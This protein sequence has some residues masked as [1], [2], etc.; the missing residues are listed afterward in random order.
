MI[1]KWKATIEQ[2]KL[3]IIDDDNYQKY[4]SNLQGEVEVV[5]KRVRQKRSTR[6]N[7]YYWACVKIISDE[8]GYTPWEIHNL[9]KSQFLKELIIIN[10]KAYEVTKS[11]PELDTIGFS[12]DYM[13]RIKHW[14]SAELNIVLPDP[15]DYY[16]NNS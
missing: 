11:T 15:R 14:A 6:Q 16:E 2:G 1:P 3:T 7:S 5:V 4:L 10:D 8:T 12:M 9:L 13:E